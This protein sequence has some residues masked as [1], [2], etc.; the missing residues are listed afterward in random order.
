MSRINFILTSVILHSICLSL[1]KWNVLNFQYRFNSSL[2]INEGIRSKVIFLKLDLIRQQAKSNL[3]YTF[4]CHRDNIPTIRLAAWP[5]EGDF[6]DSNVA[7][8]PFPTLF[9]QEPDTTSR[10]V[11]NNI[12]KT[13]NDLQRLAKVFFI[14]EAISLPDC[15]A[16]LKKPRWTLKYYIK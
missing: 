8:G 2:S 1:I 6:F 10:A 14:M 16:S 5:P 7:A 9:S 3:F 4:L 11:I 15:P 12:A 13:N